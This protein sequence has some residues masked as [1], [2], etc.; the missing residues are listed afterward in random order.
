M[1]GHDGV[2][3]DGGGEDEG[4]LKATGNVGPLEFGRRWAWMI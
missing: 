1:I 3:M 4:G 2:Y